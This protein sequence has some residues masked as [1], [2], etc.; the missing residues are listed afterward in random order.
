MSTDKYLE[1]L[2]SDVDAFN[3]KRP[4]QLNFFAAD[5][6]GAQLVGADLSNVNLEKSDLSDANL[7]GANLSKARLSGADMCNTNFRS[8]I[9][10][11]SKWDEAYAEEADF[12]DADLSGASMNEAEILQSK[13]ERAILENTYLKNANLTGCD[14]SGTEMVRARLTG[15]NATDADFSHS[16]LNGIKLAKANL[17]KCNFQHSQLVGALFAETTLSGTDLSD[18]NLQ[19]ANFDKADMRGANFTG[20]DLTRADLTGANLEGVDFSTATMEEV[21]ADLGI[22][23]VE[24]SPPAPHVFIE[25]PDICISGNHIAAIWLNHESPKKRIRLIRSQ[26]GKARKEEIIALPSPADMVKARALVA[27]PD[28]FV[29][30]FIEE[31]ASGKFAVFDMIPP[32]GETKR[33]CRF[34]LDYQTSPLSGSRK[35]PNFKLIVGKERLYLYVIARNYPKVRVH[36]IN[37]DGKHAA[38]SYDIPTI[39]GL[40]GTKEA[41]ALTKGGTM[42]VLGPRGPKDMLSCPSTFPG[43]QC[44]ISIHPQ[45]PS[46]AW[47]PAADAET[48]PKLGVFAAGLEQEQSIRFHRKAMIQQI[49][50][51]HDED[52]IWVCYMLSPT[53]FEPAEVWVGQLNGIGNYPVTGKETEHDED[54]D[55]IYTVTDN[56][57]VYLVAST[58]SGTLM[59]F[60][61]GDDS[62]KLTNTI[63]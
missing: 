31:R 48:V 34:R 54:V 49:S 6:S 24:K 46:A 45:Q 19:K 61:L 12:T 63:K 39:S 50:M 7:E 4:P 42:A 5:L 30:M 15:C 36:A 25:E 57:K 20:S 51:S 22:F 40:I 26:I 59:V 13:F 27:V 44:D 2:L 32:K 23:P 28:G 3:D 35:F 29:S 18:T 60:K 33:F 56:N 37:Y 62:A 17:S 21:G 8:I 41:V 1:L 53:G 11:R 14:F 47:L 10:T 9:A 38:N 16:I 43:R 55:Q 52:E 58:I